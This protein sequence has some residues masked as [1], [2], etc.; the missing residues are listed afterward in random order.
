MRYNPYNLTGAQLAYLAFAYDIPAKE[1]M[2]G[3]KRR[4]LYRALVPFMKDY[5]RGEIKRLEKEE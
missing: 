1:L 5:I 3:R 2:N 4:K